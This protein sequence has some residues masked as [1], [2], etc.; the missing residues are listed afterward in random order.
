MK[1]STWTLIALTV[2]ATQACYRPIWVEIYN[3]SPGDITLSFDN[4]AE[5]VCTTPFRGICIFRWGEPINIVAEGRRY[6]Y[7]KPHDSAAWDDPKFK[8]F[9]RGQRPSF[10]VQFN[11]EGEILLLRVGSSFP[12]SR[13]QSGETR[14]FPMRAQ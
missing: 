4:P 12:I 7:G 6:A 3:N 8:V 1:V 2:V 9:D 11:T 13:D 5:R 10:R 14:D